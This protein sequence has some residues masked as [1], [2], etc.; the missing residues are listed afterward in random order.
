[1]VSHITLK[2]VVNMKR[3]YLIAISLFITICINAQNA[4]SWNEL[5]VLIGAGGSL[6]CG[7]EH[8]DKN[9]SHLSTFEDWSPTVNV[10]FYRHLTKRWALGA[11]L[12][13]MHWTDRCQEQ[14]SPWNGVS[15]DSRHN[16]YSVMPAVKY[17]WLQRKH[18]RIHSSAALGI[19]FNHQKQIYHGTVDKVY[20]DPAWDI[21]MLGFEIGGQHLFGIVDLNI[22]QATMLSAGINYCW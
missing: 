5:N 14:A 22:G 13:Y 19:G 9:I 17:N 16:C 11:R 10:V 15:N 18:L 20:C 7:L 2:V 1:M 3:I 21:T 12:S 4:R 6:C 8:N